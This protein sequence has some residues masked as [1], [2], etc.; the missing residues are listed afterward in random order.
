MTARNDHVL[1]QVSGLGYG[2]DTIRGG[3]SMP[4]PH[5]S[6][7]APAVAALDR[8]VARI[9]GQSW[10]AEQARALV[11]RLLDAMAI[12][13][14]RRVEV[15]GGVLVS[16]AVRPYWET[17]LAA[18]EAHERLW[19][20]DAELAEVVEAVSTVLLARAEAQDEAR[21]MIGFVETQLLSPGRALKD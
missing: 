14:D 5:Q 8:A 13:Y 9:A 17:G 4:A 1:Y 21:A 10:T 16:E 2:S 11:S 3:T 6:P 7:D 19:R 18:A 20:N 12:D 15:L